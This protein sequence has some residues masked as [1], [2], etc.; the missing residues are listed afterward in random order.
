MEFKSIKETALYVADLE[1]T[2]DFYH[3]IL[4][5]PIITFV[6][7]QHVF[8]RAGE[9]VLLCFNA[10][11]SKTKTGVP[12]HYGAGNLHFAFECHDGEYE[13]WKTL[14]LKNGIEIEQE[15]IWR[16]NRK[17]F[18]FRDPD[19]HSVEIVQSGIWGF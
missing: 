11:H 4:G 6:A 2:K 18:Y 9:S 1:Q 3:G 13:N 10:A 17:S 16:A 12:P 14:L 5:L 19:Q 8:F 7:G 15:I